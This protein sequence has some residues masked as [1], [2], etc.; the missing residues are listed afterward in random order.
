VTTVQPQWR[1]TE[2][3]FVAA[4]EESLNPRLWCWLRGRL[5]WWTICGTVRVCGTEI[6][7]PGVKVEAFDVDWLQ[8]DPLGA[9]TTD[10]SGHFRIDYTPADFER[11]PFSP[12][13]NI[14]L[15]PGPDVYFRITG[16][17]GILLAEPRSQGRTPGR[18]N[19]GP[20]LCVHLC[21]KDQPP[22]TEPYP[23]FDHIGIY[24]IDTGIDSGPAGTG[25]TVADNRAFFSTIPLKGVLARTFGG[26]P[27]QY[28]FE[29]RTLPGGPWQPVLPNQIAPTRIGTIEK[30]TLGGVVTKDV[31]VNGVAGPTTVAVTPAADGWISVP[32]DNSLTTGLFVP[33]EYL[34]DLDTTT[35]MLEHRDASGITGGNSAAPAGLVS[36]EFFGIR[37]RIRQAGAPGTEVAAGECQRLAIVNTDYDHVHKHGSWAPQLVDDQLD[38]A[39]LDVAELINSPCGGIGSSLTVMYTAAHPNLGAVSISLTGPAGT[40]HYDLPTPVTPNYFNQTTALFD[41]GNN[42]VTV[43]NLPTCAYL[44]TL[45]TTVLVTNGENV[46]SPVYDQVAFCKR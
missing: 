12:L 40:Y 6:P 28:R 15:V 2:A 45:S 44:L 14:E 34:L 17:S 27:L 9:A 35:L 41:A 24:R 21:V 1:R 7:V 10:A 8:D 5:G 3:G 22:S 38:I 18:Q 19:V 39:S 29:T 13:I 43:A 37:M 36:D 26:Q 46:P 32:Q 31:M 4:W 33:G 30:L 16:P 11:T 25:L 20:C 42:P 23:W